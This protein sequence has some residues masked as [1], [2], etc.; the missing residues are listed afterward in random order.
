MQGKL[1]LSYVYSN[2]RMQSVYL[3]DVHVGTE[4]QIHSSATTLVNVHLVVLDCQLM[5]NSAGD[6]AARTRFNLIHSTDAGYCSISTV[7]DAYVH[8]SQTYKHFT[9]TI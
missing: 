7:L 2:D 9:C 6:A 4:S 8:D 5:P 1:E 3:R